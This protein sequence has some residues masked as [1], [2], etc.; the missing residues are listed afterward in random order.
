MWVS[1]VASIVATTVVPR[2]LVGKLVVQLVTSVLVG[3]CITRE[4]QD[5]GSAKSCEV[6]LSETGFLYRA[7]SA[8]NHVTESIPKGIQFVANLTQDRQEKF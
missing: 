8:S 6:R 7:G 2:S 3:T 4:P 1:S 5:R